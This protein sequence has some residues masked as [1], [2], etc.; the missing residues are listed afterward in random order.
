MGILALILLAN[1]ELRERGSCIIV[2]SDTIIACEPFSLWK[3]NMIF[4][5]VGGDLVCLILVDLVLC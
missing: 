4:F 5:F 3:K 1:T 2:V